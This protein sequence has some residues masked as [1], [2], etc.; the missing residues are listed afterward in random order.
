MTTDQ[1]SQ[2]AQQAVTHASPIKLVEMLL[3]GAIKFLHRA[4]HA[5]AEKDPES[6]HNNILRVYAIIAELMATLDFSNGGEIAVKLEQ[7]YEFI[8]HLLKE[9]DIKKERQ[10]L[11]QVLGVLEPLLVT[12]KEAFSAKPQ[13]ENENGTAEKTDEAEAVQR[14]KLDM[15]G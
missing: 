6:A 15:V 7:C 2:Y 14:K 9:A 1:Y 3:E 8:L 11:D 12:W 13:A 4:R 10:P 5:I